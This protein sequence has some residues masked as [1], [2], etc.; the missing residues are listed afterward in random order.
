MF[1]K[2]TY[3][4]LFFDSTNGIAPTSAGSVTVTTTAKGKFSGKAAGWAR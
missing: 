1:V 3:N 4:G 2:G